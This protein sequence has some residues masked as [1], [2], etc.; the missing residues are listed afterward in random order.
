MS[1][2]IQL[3]LTSQQRKQ[4]DKFIRSGT[5]KARTLTKAR[6]LLMTDHSKDA[7]RTDEQ[8]ASALGVS[9]RT[10]VRV[11]KR[12]AQ[13]G[14]EAAL[15]D[16]AR[17]GRPPKITGD[18]EAQIAV[19]ACSEPPPGHA[20]WSLRLLADKIVELGY[21][22]SISHVAVSNRLKKRAATLAREILVH[23]HAFRAFRRQNGGCLG[24]LSSSV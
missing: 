10:I 13:G 16:K 14:L 1:T 19:L 8:I 2:H 15:H 18:I 17:C 12:C 4:L 6:I 7:H 24:G 11:R 5:A 22:D 23:R 3:H 21:L 20:R 9:M